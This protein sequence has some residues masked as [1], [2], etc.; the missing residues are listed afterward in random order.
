MKWRKFRIL[1]T[2]SFAFLGCLVLL[3][4]GENIHSQTTHVPSAVITTFLRKY[5]TTTPVQWKVVDHQFIA[6]FKLGKKHCSA[7]FSADGEWERSVSRVKWTWQLPVSVRDVLDRSPYKEWYIEKMYKIESP[8]KK[9]F[10]RLFVNNANLLDGDHHDGFQETC[11][12][13]ISGNNYI[14]HKSRPGQSAGF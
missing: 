10:Y 8:G 1:R 11:Y 4:A 7:F 2:H 9:G 13:D 14:L 12:L 6:R 5:Q 3:L